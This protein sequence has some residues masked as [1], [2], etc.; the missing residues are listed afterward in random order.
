ME[1]KFQK[2]IVNAHAVGKYYILPLDPPPAP[3]R[4]TLL[5]K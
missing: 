3:P 4:V 1:R 2:H 5:T